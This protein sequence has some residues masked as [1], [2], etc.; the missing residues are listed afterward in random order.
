MSSVAPVNWQAVAALATLAAVLVALLPIFRDALRR[1]AQA[2]SLRLRL[3]SKLT[4]LR[5]SLGT[6]IQAGR[7]SH[8]AAVL[9]PGAFR[10]A[11]RSVL[12]MMKESAVLEPEEQDQ[13]GVVVAN[14]EMAALLYGTEEL[15]P[16]SA[17]NVIDLIDRAV[18]VMSAHGLL[19][20]RVEKPWEE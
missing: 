13:L 12:E 18:A 8:P 19:H 20:G 7:A 3:S 9:S 17:T 15:H 5:P 4:V 10:E 1:K 6:V 2:R 11:S 14:L 16:D